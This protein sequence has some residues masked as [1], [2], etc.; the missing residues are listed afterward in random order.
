MNRLLVV[1]ISPGAQVP[2]TSEPT[3]ETACLTPSAVPGRQ[4]GGVGEG[5]GAGAVREKLLD[6]LRAFTWACRAGVALQ[7]VVTVAVNQVVSVRREARERSPRASSR[8]ERFVQR[9]VDTGQT[10]R[11]EPRGLGRPGS[12]MHV[13]SDA[14]GLPLLVGVS[15]RSTHD[16]EGLKPMVEGH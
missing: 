12:M 13:L 9:A 16:S 1:R 2:A 8:R 15:A 6:P 11:S 10:H 5:G 14:N 4:S 3:A 7:V